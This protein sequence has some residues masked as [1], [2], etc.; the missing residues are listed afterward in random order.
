MEPLRIEIIVKVNENFKEQLVKEVT[1][2]VERLTG[3]KPSIHWNML[4]SD[5]I[6]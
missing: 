4:T 6:D 1:E 3:N 2:L 5:K